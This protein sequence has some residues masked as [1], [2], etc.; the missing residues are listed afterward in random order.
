MNRN[1]LLVSTF[2]NVSRSFIKPQGGQIFIKKYLEIHH[3]DL[4]VD[5]VDPQIETVEKV[6]EK[7]HKSYT[8]IG[9][10]CTYPTLINTA[11]LIIEAYKYNPDSVYFLGGPGVSY[12]KVY[13]ICYADI[14]IY[15]E[16]EKIISDLINVI[17]DRDD[18]S[19]KK[20]LI[21]NIAGSFCVNCIKN[22]DTY[23][24]KSSC[25]TNICNKSDLNTIIP[26]SDW[27][28]KLHKKYENWT[29][30]QLNHVYGFPV[31]LSRG[32]ASLGCKFCSSFSWFKSEFGVRYC[33]VSVAYKLI[34]DINHQMLYV[35]EILFE[36]DNLLSNTEW[37]QMFVQML[38][39]GINAGEIN[40]NNRY[41]IKS[42][43][44]LLNHNVI[45]KL[46]KIGKVQ[47]NV[48]IET[49]SENILI[50]L[51]KTKDPK[52]Y[53]KKV[54]DIFKYKKLY[55]I[56]FHCYMIFF[57]PKTKVNDLIKSIYLASRFLLNGIE[58][59]CYDSLLVFPGSKYDK[60][61]KNDN[62][63]VNWVKYI[64]PLHDSDIYTTHLKNE[65]NID[66]EIYMPYDFVINDKEV[67]F[68][69]DKSQKIFKWLFKFYSEAFNWKVRTS[70]RIAFVKVLSYVIIIIIQDINLKQRI[71]FINLLRK[72]A[73]QITI[74]SDDAVENMAC[75]DT[76]VFA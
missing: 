6:I 40:R 8:Y 20:E 58:I 9:F 75:D 69:Y 49:Y 18:L 39:E 70:F 74:L 10:Y 16:G 29:S 53:I 71:N 21:K 73:K 23:I 41:I 72:L 19:K 32:C 27:E 67:K 50:E 22:Q 30:E 68:I 46:S 33:D 52:A 63:M 44:D 64:N 11:K 25:L 28:I 31:F 35:S 47:I 48:G 45:E 36:D 60:E 37:F 17:W 54:N 56:K 34:K 62:S 13:Q 66:K 15:G 59:S 51:N 61:W 2:E 76:V 43:L 4:E 38:I 65:L 55:H 14:I 5:I 12:D 1:L 42:R 7:F 24:G 57:T 3:P 26:L